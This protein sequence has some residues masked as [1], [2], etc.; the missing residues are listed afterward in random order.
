MLKRHLLQCT[1]LDLEKAHYMDNTENVNTPFFSFL[2][3]AK[4]MNFLF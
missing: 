3:N 1:T 4:L 2:Y